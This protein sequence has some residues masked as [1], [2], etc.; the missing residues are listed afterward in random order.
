MA[1]RF[2]AILTAKREGVSLTSPLLFT[3]LGVTL[4]PSST[5]QLVVSVVEVVR[6]WMRK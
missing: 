4:S 3:R 1:L 6:Y 5:R 2:A